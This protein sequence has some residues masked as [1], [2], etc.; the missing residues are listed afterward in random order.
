MKRLPRTAAGIFVGLAG[1]AILLHAL[2]MLALENFK[3]GFGFTNADGAFSLD[4]LTLFIFSPLSSLLQGVMSLILG[5]SLLW[6]A[7]TV[8]RGLPVPTK[9]AHPT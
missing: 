2:Y 3:S 5:R 1:A 8:F 4:G 6:Y 9:M 7:G